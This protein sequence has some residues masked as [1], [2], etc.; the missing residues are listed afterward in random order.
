MILQWFNLS[1]YQKVCSFPELKIFCKIGYEKIFTVIKY[2]L[3]DSQQQFASNSIYPPKEG[4]SELMIIEP[5]SHIRSESS[6]CEPCSNSSL[7][8]SSLRVPLSM[9]LKPR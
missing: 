4:Q 6:S 2:I 7:L 5:E 1:I 3:M 9:N 8:S